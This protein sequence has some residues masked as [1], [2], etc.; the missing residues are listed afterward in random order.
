M[1]EEESK[2]TVAAAEAESETK[3][4][5]MEEAVEEK[6]PEPEVAKDAEG[7][8]PAEKEE[9]KAADETEEKPAD[10]VAVA[11]EPAK[12]KE[13]E[14]DAVEETR[15]TIVLEN[16][17]NIAESSVN[18][19]PVQST[20]VLTTF[21][22]CGLQHLFAGARSTVGLKG[23]RYM[24]E[25]KILETQSRM[26]HNT[27]GQ[28]MQTRHLAR[29][30]LSK[31]GTSP[32]LGKESDCI[33]IDS[34]GYLTLGKEGD[35]KRVFNQALGRFATLAVVVN[36]DSTS[37]LCN[38][39]SFFKDG[40]R[41]LD[42]QPIPDS[43]KGQALFPTVAYKNMSVQM[44][45]GPLPQ[46]QLPFK[47]NMVSRAAAE[48]AIISNTALPEQPEVY[49][50]I[51]LPEQGFFDF[52]DGFLAENPSV[53]ELSERKVCDWAIQSGL[54]KTSEGA[55]RDKLNAKF[56]VPEIDD[57]SVK[58]MLQHT[59]PP[60]RRSCIIP[61]LKANWSAPTRKLALKHFVGYKKVAL[62]VVGEPNE[63]YKTRVQSLILGEKRKKAEEE[64][65]KAKLEQKRKK[66]LERKK[67]MLTKKASD[68][69]EAEEPEEPEEELVVELTDE[70][71][72]VVH[73]KNA[74]PDLQ[75]E[76]LSKAYSSFTLPSNED[77]FDEIRYIWQPQE[78]AELVLKEWMFNK[79]LT[80][81]V[82]DI[83][84]GD[85]FREANQKWLASVRQ[86]RIAQDNWKN[87]AKKKQLLAKLADAKKKAFEK[88]KKEAE[89]AGDEIPE[90]EEEME[91]DFEFLDVDAVE[92]VADIGNGQPLFSE[93]AHE[94]WQLLSTRYELHL[95]VHSFR[96]DLND[97]DRP[98]FSEKDLAFYY[99]RYFKKTFDF[100]MFGVKDLAGLMA[101]SKDIVSVTPPNNFI[102]VPLPD[103]ADVAVFVKAT[104]EHRRDRQRRLDAG[105]ESA[106]LK[107]PRQLPSQ[108]NKPQATVSSFNRGVSQPATVRVPPQHHQVKPHQISRGTPVG[109]AH[110]HPQPVTVPTSFRGQVSRVVPGA[111]P[112]VT[113]P[114]HAQ[115]P[116]RPFVASPG[117]AA[118]PPSKFQRTGAPGG[119]FR[120]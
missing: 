78:K 48:D 98:G 5:A 43:L 77:G 54:R 92:D 21:N 84:V 81:R 111:R 95:L 2:E 106:Q 41:I 72:A 71:R 51:G 44:N 38:T 55:S 96:A 14:A 24:F 85:K 25:V 53:L 18:V 63:E 1:A 23:G 113:M 31:Q 101:I 93:F 115:L 28:G 32:L 30:G 37:E 105:D 80:Q 40:T 82:E 27:H 58:K 34:D 7:E 39:I 100:R 45:L 99:N 67:K 79:K 22:D 70:E 108:A 47:C 20:G 52:V 64:R 86:W 91:I 103:D 110:R 6:S 61:E 3:D 12:P 90:P 116:K 87:P 8:N 83:K 109:M 19:L 42:P 46:R 60:L 74:K 4:V 65:R 68:P 36:Q 49:F 69:E 75:E 11:K 13:P 17:V 56:G 94:D 57:G 10:K 15:D 73:R 76:V 50:P 97:A 9:T 114:A 88:R 62:V 119:V 35:R 112:G 118:Y 59:A 107:F 26:E 89:E 117:Q 16:T 33:C 104:E 120:R 29:I 102:D 66:D